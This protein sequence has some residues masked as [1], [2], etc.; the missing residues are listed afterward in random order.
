MKPHEIDEIKT[1]LRKNRKAMV[2]ILDYL[3]LLG[4]KID[5]KTGIKEGADIQKINIPI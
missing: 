2:E 3:V 1:E 5:A 4:G